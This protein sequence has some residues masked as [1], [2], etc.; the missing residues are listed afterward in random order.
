MGNDDDSNF[1]HTSHTYVHVASF[2]PAFVFVI[3]CGIWVFVGWLETSQQ[4]Q[5]PTFCLTCWAELSFAVQQ[6]E[7]KI[8]TFEAG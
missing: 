8:A 5:R 7:R 4:Q 6:M 3:C 2:V 1:P